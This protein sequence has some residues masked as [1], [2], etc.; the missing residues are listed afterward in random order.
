MAL[1]FWFYEN[2]KRIWDEH[3]RI[4][5][6]L[7]CNQSKYIIRRKNLS[8]IVLY[9]WCVLT[10]GFDLKK[11]SSGYHKNHYQNKNMFSFRRR[12]IIFS[13]FSPVVFNDTSEITFFSFFF[14]NVFTILLMIHIS[15]LM[16]TDFGVGYSGMR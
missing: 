14:F 6:F 8:R 12:N 10:I 15:T 1:F 13:S 9:R 11:S 7:F 16:H 3:T 4:I 5:L 2:A